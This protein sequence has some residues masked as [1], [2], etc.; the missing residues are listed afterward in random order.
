MEARQWADLA[1]EAIGDAGHW[2]GECR[3]LQQV[4]AELLAACELFVD[5]WPVLPDRDTPKAT[6]DVIAAW[7]AARAAIARAKGGA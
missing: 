3:Q 4:N 1:D 7:R 2:K 6:P 5:L